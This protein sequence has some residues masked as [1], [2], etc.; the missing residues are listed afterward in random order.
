[1]DL[2]VWICVLS[3]LHTW[4]FCAVLAQTS[5]QT[6]SAAGT[7]A[8]H[9]VR[10]KRC[11]CATFLDKECVY[12]CHLDIIWVNTPERVVSYGLGNAP[13]ARRALPDSMATT[14]APRCRCVREDDGSCANFC[15]RRDDDARDAPLGT[16][17]GGGT[18]HTDRMKKDV[19][20]RAVL[21]A[22]LLLQTWRDRGRHRARAPPPPSNNP[23]TLSASLERFLQRSPL[24][25]KGL[26]FSSGLV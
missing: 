13:R 3:A 14:R 20:W 10:H 9:H 25:H 12:F 2:K 11:S 5:A 26:R 8:Q 6:P 19:A 16:K 4:T 22:R 1:M 23:Q 21:K 15:H 24:P 18:R 17:P 7:S